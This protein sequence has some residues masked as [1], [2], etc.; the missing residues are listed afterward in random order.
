MSGNGWKGWVG[1]GTSMEGIIVP[2]LMVKGRM[3][4]GWIFMELKSKLSWADVDGTKK[5]K[6]CRSANDE[7]SAFVMLAQRRSEPGVPAVNSISITLQFA[8]VKPCD[9]KLTLLYIV[10]G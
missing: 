9:V 6:T 8:A 5:A 10:N 1:E 3:L 2:K 7:I 4:T